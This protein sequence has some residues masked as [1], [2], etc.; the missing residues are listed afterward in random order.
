MSHSEFNNGDLHVI[1]KNDL[2]PHV[3]GRYC[4]CD[5]QYDITD[6]GELIV[7]HNSYDAR[8][9]CEVSAIRDN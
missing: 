1:P 9:L 8:E 7:V 5:P 6:Y 2:E 3:I 4:D